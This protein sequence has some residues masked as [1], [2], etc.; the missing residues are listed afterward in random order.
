MKYNFDG[1]DYFVL[2]GLLMNVAAGVLMLVY[3]LL[4]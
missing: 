1:F 3:W 4:Y 2:A